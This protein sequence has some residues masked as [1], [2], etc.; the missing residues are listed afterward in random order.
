MFL[1]AVVVA[2]GNKSSTYMKQCHQLL[3]ACRPG[4]LSWFCTPVAPIYPEVGAPRLMSSGRKCEMRKTSVSMN[5]KSIRAFFSSPKSSDGVTKTEA[6]DTNANAWK[7]STITSPSIDSHVEDQGIIKRAR[8]D[9][10]MLHTDKKNLNLNDVLGKS[11]PAIV[12]CSMSK[13]AAELRRKLSSDSRHSVLKL[14]K[15]MDPEW[16]CVLE[17]RIISDKFR[18][19]ADFIEK[20]RLGS[21]PIYPPSDQVFSWSR[22]CSPSDVR[23]VIL[24]QDPYHGPKQAHGLAFSVQRPVPPPPSLL[25]MFKEIKSSIPDL[26]SSKWPP[27]HGDLTG[28]AR[29]GVLLLNAVLTVRASMANSHKDKGWEFLTDEVVRYL[30]HNRSHLVFMLWGANAQARGAKIDRQRHLVLE[31]PHPSPLSASRGFFGCGHF[32]RTN[33]YLQTHGQTPIN[34]A[35][36]D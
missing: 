20:E 15:D 29:Q 4:I 8:V 30:S 33:E 36:L 26:D 7:Q 23:V 12:R 32:A 9:N 25:N 22:F 14:I 21:T 2:S 13:R 27:N 10:P 3:A 16:I 6:T 24:G 31:S 35:K 19:L 17:N 11:D 1:G 5:Q 28:W 18:M 34:W